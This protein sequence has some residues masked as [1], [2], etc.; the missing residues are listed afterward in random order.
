MSYKLR[1]ILECACVEGSAPCRIDMGGTLDIR[2][3]YYALRHLYPCTFN[4]ALEL[5]TRVRLFP[6]RDSLVKVSSKGFETAEFPLDR[7][8]FDHPLG[9][10]FAIAAYFRIEGVHIDIHSASPPRSA[11]GGSS[12]A[13]AALVTVFTRALEK[14]GAN[15][16]SRSQ[17]ALLAHGIEESIAGVPC[18]L[19]DQLAAV[20]G[21]VNTWYWPGKIEGP[22]FK[23]EAIFKESFFDVFE[24][25]L[26]LAYCGLPHESKNINGIWIRQFLSGRSRGI[27]SDI[28]QC[29][30][31][32][33]A[34]LKERNFV[35]AAT[36]M[37]METALRRK[38]TPEVFDEMGEKLY[39]SALENQCGVRFTGAGGGGCVWALGEIED[40]LQLKIRWKKIL[41]ERKEAGLLN[42]RIDTEGVSCSL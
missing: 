9:L 16:Y 28:V 13:A 19:Q 23:K 33:V 1:D 25:H 18:G 12:S 39:H 8:P 6:Y 42:V 22:A 37:N 2:T 14:T 31:T 20:Y 27:W 38:M 36:A 3:F 4:I 35:E 17:I 7:V 34:A 11:L 15:S 30:R 24:K 41:K 21:G 40:I 29:T 10:I 26:L 5:R 32:F